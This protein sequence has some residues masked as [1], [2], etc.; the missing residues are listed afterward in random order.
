MDRKAREDF[1]LTEELMM[2]N[3]AAAMENA[4]LPYV[5]HESSRYI[6]RPHVLVLCGSGNNGADG[7]ALARRLVCHEFCVT[8]CVVDDPKA[9]LCQLQKKRADLSGVMFTDLYSLD[10]FIEEKSF[11]V[12]FGI[13][14]WTQTNLHP[15]AQRRMNGK[16]DSKSNERRSNIFLRQ[17]EY[18][19][20]K[21]IR[22][23]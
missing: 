12:C 1:C 18:L 14:G 16:T 5:F 4:V 17:F 6:D 13:R 7:Y 11:P 10:D 15:K 2:E 3:A 22:N 19:R 20:R 8:C 9:E 23:C 21:Y